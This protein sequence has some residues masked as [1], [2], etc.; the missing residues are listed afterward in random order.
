MSPRSVRE[1]VAAL[2]PRYFLVRKAEKIRLLNELCRLTGYHRQ[3][4]IRC[5]HRAPQRTTTPRGRPRQY[6]PDLLPALR[7]VWEAS[8]RLCS[9]RLAPFLPD[10]VAALERH[11]ALVLPPPLRAQLLRIS[12]ATIDRF[13]KSTRPR[14]LR[15]PLLLN[16][17]T[18]ALRTQIPVRTF[19]DW[20]GVRPGS[21]QADL[22]MHCGESLAGFFLATLVT[23]DVATG[24]TECQPVWGKGYE[25][26]GSAIHRVSQLLPFALHALHTDN[27]GAFL[28]HILVQWCHKKHIRFTRGR[29]YRKN[30]QA[31]AEQRNWAQ[32]RRLIGYDRYSSKTAYAHLAH[33]YGLLHLY[34][35]FFQP[36]AKL[37]TKQRVGSRVTKRYEL[38]R[39]PYQRLLASGTLVFDIRQKLDALYRSLNPVELH[40]Q[41]Q[42]ALTRLWKLADKPGQ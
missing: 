19:G 16:P 21:L 41:I 22:V 39:T 1:I 3:S 2:R 9:K 36:T 15:R 12:P 32:V 11:G 18:A 25:R 27:D 30:D 26:V 6:G 7:T 17:A 8:D 42:A 38:A 28:N 5:L 29:P 23:V 14:G 37:R 10:F 31:Y 24:W 34:T 13:L 40:T 4:V 35:N 20:A 33:L